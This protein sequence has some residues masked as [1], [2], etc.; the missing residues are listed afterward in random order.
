MATSKK[1]LTPTEF[2]RR[3][4]ESRQNVY[5]MI[6]R[7]KRNKVEIIIEQHDTIMIP[8]SELERYLRRQRKKL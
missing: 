3:T 7:N 8:Y 1:A 5:N 6:H 4:G 2:A